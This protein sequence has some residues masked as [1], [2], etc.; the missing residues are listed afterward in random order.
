MPPHAP[1]PGQACRI[2]SIR[3]SSVILEV[4][5]APREVSISLTRIW[6]VYYPTL[7]MHRQY[8]R[9]RLS[10]NPTNSCIFLTY[11]YRKKRTIAGQSSSRRPALIVPP[12]IM[13]VGRLCLAAAIAHP[14][15]SGLL[16]YRFKVLEQI[17]TV[18]ITTGY[19][20][21]RRWP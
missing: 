20:D 16:S 3:S 2:T 17:P 9:Y 8:W 14:G 7:H 1:A 6:Y 19:T 10:E 11:S 13:I 5:Y 21:Y 12:Y 18:L 4:V 15:T